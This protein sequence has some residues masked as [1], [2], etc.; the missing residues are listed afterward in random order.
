VAKHLLVLF[1]LLPKLFALLLESRCQL[2][3][4]LRESRL[5]LF[6]LL[7]ESRVLL[8]FPDDYGDRRDKGR[9][10][11]EQDRRPDRKYRDG[12]RRHASRLDATRSRSC[13][14]AAC[15]DA[16]VQRVRTGSPNPVRAC[17]STRA[18]T[19]RRVRAA[20][21]LAGGVSIRDTAS[22]AGLSY[23]HLLAVEH[24]E[25]P[26]LASD[27]VDLGRVLDVPAAWLRDGWRTSDAS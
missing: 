5:E 2:F 14:V 10:E 17:N 26:L 12:D 27:A 9:G 16:R 8:A 13:L 11:R 22:A 4:L 21:L 19:A 20:R 15:K 1:T 24:G 6:A 3:A 18:Q 23:P 7:V 25:Q